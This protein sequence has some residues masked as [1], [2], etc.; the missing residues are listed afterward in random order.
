M[1]AREAEELMRIAN[2][3]D[4]IE[5]DATTAVTRSVAGNAARLLLV[6]IALEGHR[7]F[8]QQ[9]CANQPREDDGNVE[10][11]G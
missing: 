2:A 11:S 8:E 3:L 4:R 1:T 10:L 5:R 6:S 9:Y 7:I